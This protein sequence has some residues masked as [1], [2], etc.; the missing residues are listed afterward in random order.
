M[1]FKNY[2]QTGKNMKQPIFH[3]GDKIS[4]PGTGSVAIKIS[5]VFVLNDSVFY[6]LKSYF[7]QCFLLVN[8][9]DIEHKCDDFSHYSSSFIKHDAY[10]NALSKC[11]GYVHDS[12]K[13]FDDQERRKLKIQLINS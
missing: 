6:E 11:K 1:A 13:V 5:N 4:V 12:Y 3:K 2:F 10:L 8:E 7:G 9:N